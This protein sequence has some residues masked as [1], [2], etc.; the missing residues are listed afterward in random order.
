[1]KSIQFNKITI[2]NFLSVGSEP[3]SVEFR[4]GL[5]IITGVNR[6]KDDR[7]NG[8]GKS[9]IADAIYFA[10]FGETLRDLK[11]EFIIN[12]VNKKTCE[13]NLEVTVTGYNNK[14]TILI[15]RTLDPSKCYIYID[16]DDKTRDSI[17]NTNAFIMSKFECTPEIFQ[18]CV[19]MTVN[20]TV[21]FMA[22]KKQE[23]RKFIEDILNLS[24]FSNM[25]NDAKNDISERKKTYELHTTRFDEAS[26]TIE[27]LK[28]QADGIKQEKKFKKEKYLTRKQNNEKELTSLTSLV[29]KF[30]ALDIDKNKNDIQ[31]LSTKLEKIDESVKKIRD[32]V[33]SMR[34]Q[35][36]IKEKDMA[37]IGTDKNKCPI[38]LKPVTDHD[39][40]MIKEEKK[41]LKD[42]IHD[43]EIQVKQLI[44]KEEEQAELD[45]KINKAI[46]SLKQKHNEHQLKL[47]EQENIKQRID[48]LNKWQKELEV[49]LQDIDLSNNQAE[50]SLTEYEE[51]IK[52]IS[53]KIEELKKDLAKLDVVKFILSEEG[54]KSYIVKKILQIF[55]T[56]LTYYLKKMDANCICKFNEYFEESIID[57]KGKEC[58]YFNFSGAER[59]NIDLA[60]L[61]TFMDIRRLQG[62]VSFNF[63]IYDELFDSSLDE[64]G[65]ELVIAILKERVE[66][67]KECAM[68]ISHRK[69]SIKSATGDIIF[70]EKTN[71]IT[72]RVNY[73]DY[74]GD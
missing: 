38:C 53:N 27:T 42:E 44:E 63:S 40:A 24:V 56:K 39:K 7:R 22:K 72:K 17:T 23:K 6:D 37:K 11:K 48:Q 66:K 74:Q 30:Q 73:L 57:D 25:L 51:K 43:T 58:S 71:G 20:N 28:K 1:M 18:N 50:L 12:N 16:G 55:N 46:E 31:L 67:F 62:D 64:K 54:V 26:S 21:P 19:I 61:F 59:K 68:V 15:T 14:E 2:K 60:C 33:S 29:S 8:V 9:T 10:V 47:K 34:T 32:Q 41:K 70:L 45:L 36:D 35:I 52:C 13:I 5:H 69:E 65:V 3:V 4:P 49:D